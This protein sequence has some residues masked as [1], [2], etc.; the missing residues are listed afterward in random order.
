MP[1]PELHLDTALARAMATLFRELSQQLSLERPVT[2]YLAG[3]MAVHLYTGARITSDVDAE[4]PS[5]FSVPDGLSVIADLETGESE[6]VFIDTNYNPNFSLLHEN[7]QADSIRLDL[8][9]GLIEVR[10]LSPLDLAVSKL[11]RFAENDRDDIHALAFEGLF[12]ADDLERRANE[13]L[14]AHIGNL[15][16]LRHNV[17]DAVELVRSMEIAARQR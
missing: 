2:A 10:V 13:A 15:P 17:R 9:A 4:F 14:V 5:R 8:D 12:S 11:A 7:Y 16:M 3:G 6:E 1:S